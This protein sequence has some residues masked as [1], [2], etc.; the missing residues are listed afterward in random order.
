MPA[1]EIL[2]SSRSELLP[3][4]GFLGRVQGVDSEVWVGPRAPSGK[5]VVYPLYEI[6]AWAEL[7]E[8]APVREGAVEVK[9]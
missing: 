1:S 8:K 7:P 2:M 6:Y 9:L 3:I 5:R 4:R